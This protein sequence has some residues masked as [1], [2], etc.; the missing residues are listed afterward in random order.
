MVEL[1]RECPR[2]EIFSHIS[3][4]YVNCDQPYARPVTVQ[5]RLCRRE[6]LRGGLQRGDADRHDH[7]GAAR[8]DGE[9]AGEAHRRVPEHVLV[10][11]GDE[12][13][14]PARPRRR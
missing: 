3:T 10:H 5:E 2:L 12:R 11:E 7:E 1:A 8:G 13:A 14:H 6:D 9:Q 4:A